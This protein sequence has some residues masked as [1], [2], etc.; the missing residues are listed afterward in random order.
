MKQSEIIELS[1]PELIERIEN[2]QGALG[3]MK[4]A[5]IVSP[6]DNPMQIRYSRKDIARMKTELIKRRSQE[7]A[8]E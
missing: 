2:S 4:M 3:N 7:Q 8:T 1:T 5:H 6:L